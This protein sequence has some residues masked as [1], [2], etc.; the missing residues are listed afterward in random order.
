MTKI[1]KKIY[2]I[3]FIILLGIGFLLSATGVYISYYQ[4][5]II[6]KAFQ[7]LTA[8]LDYAIQVKDIQLNLWKE[9]PTLRLV[10]RQVAVQNLEKQPKNILIAKEID[11]VFNIAH[12]IRGEYVLERISIEQGT[13]FLSNTKHTDG[14]AKVVISNTQ[15]DFVLPIALKRFILKDI[16]LVYQDVDTSK[17]YI[18]YVQQLQAPLQYKK[19]NLSVQVQ[20]QVRIEELPF[21]EFIAKSNKLIKVSAEINCDLTRQVYTCRKGNINLD[22]ANIIFQA[23]V[24]NSKATSIMNLYSSVSCLPIINIFSWLSTDYSQ[25]L[26]QYQ[27]KG[28]VSCKIQLTKK[29]ITSLEAEFVLH[30]ASL[31]HLTC[32]TPISIGNLTGRI[33]IPSILEL[34]K[35]S[36]E[37]PEYTIALGERS[38]IVGNMKLYDFEKWYVRNR[39]SF[40]VDLPTLTQTVLVS[41]IVH[42]TTGQ[43]K[44]EWEVDTSLYNFINAKD[45]H[46]IP[47]FIAKINLCDVGFM[48]NKS[49]FQ[50]QETVPILLQNDTLSFTDA[51]GHVDGKIFAI[52]GTCGNLGGFLLNL[53]PTY[54]LNAKVYAEY[55]ALDKLIHTNNTS[56]K[57][58]IDW[59]AITS[60][61]DGEVVGDIQELV[62]DKFHGN[63]LKGKVT[64]GNNQMMAD[65]VE[66]LFAGGKASLS[67]KLDF[68]IDSIQIQSRVNLKSIELPLLFYTFNNFNQD[69]LVNKNLGG[70]I[71]SEIELSLQTN[72]Q[73]QI[74]EN[75]LVA[76]VSFQLSKAFLKNFEPLQ[77]LSFYVSEKD[78]K[79]LYFS[80]LKNN[81]RI[82]NRTIYIPPMEVHTNITSIQISGTHTLDGKIDYNLV[83]PLNSSNIKST[84]EENEHA[85]AGLNLYLR[86][87]GNTQV[88]N[89]RHDNTLLKTTLKESL[90]QQ[91]KALKE[92]I[93]EKKPVKSKNVS[94]DY[95]DF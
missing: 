64:I 58:S 79:Y 85:L 11:C 19:P 12:F 7:T 20:S 49:L 88:Y 51:G 56:S 38:Q 16:K 91:S 77:K 61:L 41:S 6:E 80:N 48:Y 27:P 54:W 89:L 42:A 21:P 62:F 3:C 40:V 9:F 92:I 13:L 84:A 73:L 67:T 81:L 87:E 74:D 29:E 22:A 30:K 32:T 86:L 68:G 47:D 44:G 82:A 26:S 34:S 72:K 5:Q 75:S 18:L 65:S 46:K 57:T 37:I 93:Q 69:F 1:L 90:K 14:K 95:F 43:I 2:K 8:R 83:I 17:Q 4:K 63:N 15:T 36:L 33:S 39:S 23:D 59:R 28:N 45:K 71:S 66:I 25:Y 35:A 52:T 78:L 60:C 50:L 53:L 10:L 70:Y 76:N 31:Q 24:D 94:E 55:V